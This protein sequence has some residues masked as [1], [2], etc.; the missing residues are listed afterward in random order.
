MAATTDQLRNKSK[1]RTLEVLNQPGSTQRF[2]PSPLQQ[3]KPALKQS[4]SFLAPGMQNPFAASMNYQRMPGMNYANY[5]TKGPTIGGQLRAPMPKPGMVPPGTQPVVLPNPNAPAPTTST[6]PT[7]PAT[8][9]DELLADINEARISEGLEPFET[10]EDFQR[11][12]GI[13]EGIGNIGM[14]DGGYMSGGG[15]SSLQPQG[16]FIGG[17]MA[18]LGSGAAAAGGA[19]AKGATALGG[20][21]AKGATTLGGA[22][23]KGLGGL[24]DIAIK[25]MQNYNANMSAGAL[26]KPVEEMTREELIAYIKKTSGS[27]G[28]SGLGADLKKIGGGIT[29]AIKNRPQGGTAALNQMGDLSMLGVNMANGGPVYYPRMNGQISGPGTERSDDI[30]AML[31]DGEFVVNAKA[32][33]GIGKLDGANGSKQ[34]QR[35]KGARMM[36]AMQKAGEQAMR[37]S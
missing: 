36:Y 22:A 4:A 19:L 3:I 21:A 30:P 24:K 5:E 10:F 15:I 32:L 31:S 26:N 13:F 20:A 34:E 12:I 1:Q 2:A 17:L 18:A 14:A 9:A 28:S 37:N 23:A 35:Q 8:Q 7:D 11:D 16:M 27:S 25:G 33:R 6:E 29:D